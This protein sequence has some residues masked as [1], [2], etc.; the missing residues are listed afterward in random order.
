MRTLAVTVAAALIVSSTLAFGEPSQFGTCV[1]P[2]TARQTAPT[3]PAVPNHS[4][5]TI[6]KKQSYRCKL[7]FHVNGRAI[8]TTIPI[9]DP[10]TSV[11]LGSPAGQIKSY[12]AIQS[13]CPN[14]VVAVP[15]PEG[16][17]CCQNGKNQP[18]LC[19]GLDLRFLRGRGWKL[20]LITTAVS[21]GGMPR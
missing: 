6:P 16:G 4:S 14:L 7:R 2:L 8:V 17:I 15:T 11:I 10:N 18:H 1:S 21:T 20:R 19:S 5:A 9:S 13:K 12:A 3:V